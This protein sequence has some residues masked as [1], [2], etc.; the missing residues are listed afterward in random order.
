[1]ANGFILSRPVNENF[2]TVESPTVDSLSYGQVSISGVLIVQMYRIP[3]GG[4]G[5]ESLVKCYYIE[6]SQCL[7]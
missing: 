7:V 2:S 5:G 1:M 4:V 3:R 6:L